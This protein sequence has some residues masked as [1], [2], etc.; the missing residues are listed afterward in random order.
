MALRTAVLLAMLVAA[1]VF[2]QTDVGE[3]ALDAEQAERRG[4]DYWVGH[5]VTKDPAQAAKW[6]EQAAAAGRPYAVGLL[7]DLY[8][9]GQGV[10]RND[11]RAHELDLQ[12]AGLGVAPAQ[13]RLGYDSVYPQDRAARDPA[14]GVPWLRAAADQEHGPALYVLGQLYLFGQGVETDTELG[15][16][17]I[18]RAAELGYSPAG[19]EAARHLL[20]DDAAA[21]DVKRSLYFL[22]KAASSGYAPGAYALGK[23]YLDGRYVARDFG[24]AADWLT[25]SSEFPPAA[26]WLAELYAKGLGVEADAGRAA[27]LRER[28][29]PTIPIGARN[30]FAWELSVS[31]VAELRDGALAVEI[32]EGVTAERPSPNYLDT[33]AAAYAE[34]GRFADAARAQQRAVDALPG[35]VP[36]ATRDSYRQRVELYRSGQPYR[37]AP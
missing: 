22:N 31:P 12:A 33:L 21:D 11:D 6:L 26:L 10:E 19:T 3:K 23:L 24:V 29:L 18:T 1:R 13:A 15:W 28:V 9:M 14:A 4:F 17:L 16:R 5:G 34:A 2:A 37:E 35:N 20:D 36:G 27:E 7:A 32:M 30:D 8:R 25:R